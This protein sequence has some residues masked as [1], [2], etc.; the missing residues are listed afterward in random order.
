MRRLQ[1]PSG[2]FAIMIALYNLLDTVLGL[3]TWV[4]IAGA[5]LSWLIAFNII[6][7]RSPLVYTIQNTLDRLTD[8]LLRPIRRFLPMFGGLDL[9]PLV[10]ILLLGFLRNLLAEYWFR[11][12]A[13]G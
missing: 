3:L 1:P 12:A 8:P 10:L 5:V 4:L 13:G 7:T 2:R 11:L 6:N 9:S